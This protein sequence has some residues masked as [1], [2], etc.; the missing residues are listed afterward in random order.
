[1]PIRHGMTLGE[2]ARMFHGE[3]KMQNRL[4]VVGL[5]GW[6]RGD[7]LDATGAIWVNPSP[8]MRS[9]NAALLFPGI[10][11]LEYSR[12]YS[13][14]RG[15][16]APF[17][18]VG[19]DWINGP[20]LATKL[21]ARSIPGVRVYP[22]MFTPNDSNLKGVVCQGVRFVI[23]DRERFNSVRL[24]IE[25]A[26]MLEKLYPGKIPFEKNERLIGNK[27]TILSLKQKVDPRTIETQMEEPLAAFLAIREKYLLYR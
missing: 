26:V 19:A 8:N 15:T 16:D 14:G 13:V 12:D 22:V 21:N 27:G 1:M 7:W 20:D 5:K 23:T 4:D 25:L 2:L 6:Q 24:G 10:A 17:E 18:Q 11:M 3:R 9:L